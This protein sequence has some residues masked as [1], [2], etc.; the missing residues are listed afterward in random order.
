[1]KG[2]W[3]SYLQCISIICLCCYYT[4]LQVLFALLTFPIHLSTYLFF[5]LQE[6]EEASFSDLDKSALAISHWLQS[7]IS[8]VLQTNNWMVIYTYLF[9]HASIYLPVYLSFCSF[10]EWRCWI[11]Q[12]RDVSIPCFLYS[13]HSLFVSLSSLLRSILIIPYLPININ[14]NNN[15]SPPS[16]YQRKDWTKEMQ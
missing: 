3:S 15:T 8:L 13:H 5:S 2:R 9:I 16:I 12:Y 11:P 7:G 1:M 10:R 4:F 14:N 6:L